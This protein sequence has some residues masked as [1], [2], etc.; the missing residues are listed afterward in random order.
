MSAPVEIGL[1]IALGLALIAVA[2]LAAVV[3]RRVARLVLA[4][5]AR[6]ERRANVARA[7][8]YAASATEV[9]EIV[10][11]LRAVLDEQSRQVFATREHVTAMTSAEVER[12]TAALRALI[13]WLSAFAYAEYARTAVEPAAETTP[14]A[15]RAV[16]SRA[17]PSPRAPAVAPPGSAEPLPP[18]PAQRAAGL[19]RPAGSSRPAGA[20]P[21]PTLRPAPTPGGP[22]PSGLRAYRSA[23]TLVSMTAVTPPVA[24]GGAST[25]TE[26]EGDNPGGGSAA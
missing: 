13:E 17:R 24:R 9:A 23:P 22:P 1:M 10:A 21:S 15:D 16:G 2:I 18:A 11:P 25:R 19:T 6:N 8:L 26:G 5:N 7:A 12:M 20:P 14:M 4:E 3:P